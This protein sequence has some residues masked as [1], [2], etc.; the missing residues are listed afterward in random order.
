[1][2][3]RPVFFS[4]GNEPQRNADG[5]IAT[6]VNAQGQTVVAQAYDA[7]V[8]PRGNFM[9]AVGAAPVYELLGKRG[10]GIKDFPPV[11]TE[12]ISG[13]LGFRQHSGGH[14]SGPAWETFYKFAGKYFGK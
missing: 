13:D 2:A 4:G 10:L 11:D 6:T 3:P 1:M 5:S 7:W 14:T 9:A 12:V 8:D